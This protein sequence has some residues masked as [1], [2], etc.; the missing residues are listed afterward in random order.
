MLLI[1]P[2]TNHSAF[3]LPTLFCPSLFIIDPSDPPSNQL[4]GSRIGVGREEA[5]FIKSLWQTFLLPPSYF[6]FFFA[7]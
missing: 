6:F 2:I 7:V 5:D 4:R 3:T 1:T